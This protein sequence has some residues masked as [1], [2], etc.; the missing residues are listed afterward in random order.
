MLSRL[1]EGPAAYQVNVD[2]S[3]LRACPKMGRFCKFLVKIFGIW[4][5]IGENVSRGCKSIA[6]GST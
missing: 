2:H 4:L 6:G 5:T 1:M 3:Y